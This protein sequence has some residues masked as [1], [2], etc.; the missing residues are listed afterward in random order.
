VDNIC[1][2][3][4]GLPVLRFGRT[5]YSI[6][7][8][9][10]RKYWIQNND[11]VDRFVRKKQEYAGGGVYAG[12]NVGLLKDSIISG[13]ITQNGIF[14]VII[15]DEAGM[16]GIQE[17]LLCT[18]MAGKTILFG[19]HQQLPPFP[20][21]PTVYAKLKEKYPVIPEK[22]KKMLNI[23][24]LEY[25][26]DYRNIPVI[27]LRHSYRCQN[28]RLLR[29]ASTHF[30]DAGIKT[31]HEAEY[32]R[33]PFNERRKRYSAST[34]RLYSTSG[35]PTGI[36]S[37]QL[38]FDA[39]KPGLANHAEA[40]ICAHIFYKVAVKYPLSEISIIAPYRKQVALITETLSLDY[41]NSIINKQIN[42]KEWKKFLRTG[43]STVDSFQGQESD[44]VITCYV[45]SNANEGLGFIDNPNRMNVAHTRCRREMHITG[46]LECLKKQ[47][48]SEIFTRLE[49]TFKRDGE[50]IKLEKLPVLPGKQPDVKDNLIF[51]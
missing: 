1:G 30:Y 41:L 21:S 46:D 34:M 12:T 37:E 32:F 17:F 27:M 47:S 39:G 44:V 49:R 43:I 36:R 33:L 23:S 13:D 19:D 50:I 20:V 26:A 38:F 31:S 18:E 14:D 29:F 25:L 35:L 2:R 11:A 28:P 6:A 7:P 15:F 24:A 8:D 40:I 16:C 51:Y 5:S 48:N 22:V 4:S 45:R 10:A 9:V 3:L 42:A